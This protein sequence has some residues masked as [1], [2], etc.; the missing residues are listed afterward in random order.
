[1][2]QISYTAMPSSAGS[3]L[4]LAAPVCP[5]ETDEQRHGAQAREA[6]P[7]PSLPQDDEVMNCASTGVTALAV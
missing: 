3:R 2:K 1:M 7:R 5:S 4:L 6:S